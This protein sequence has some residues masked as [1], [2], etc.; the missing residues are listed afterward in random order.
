MKLFYRILFSLLLLFLIT[1]GFVA[2]ILISE[3][4]E[5]ASEARLN[6]VKTMSSA[7]A[8]GSLDALAVKDYELIE[9]WLSTSKAIDNFAYAYLS[10]SDGLIILHTEPEQVARQATPL[11]ELRSS[12]VRNLVYQHR[13]VIEVVSSTYLGSKHMANAHLAYYVDTTS[14]YSKKITNRLIVLLLLSLFVLSLVTYFIL[15]KALNPVTKLSIAIRDIAKSNNYSMFVKKYSDDEIGILVDSFNKMLKQ[16]QLRDDQLT[17]EK[18]HAENLATKTKIYAD[19]LELSNHELESEIS[20]RK[21]AENKLRKLSNTLEQKV[22]KRT[23]KLEEL[24][25]IVSEV[26]RNAGMAEV[27]NGILHNVGNVLNSVNVSSSVLRENISKSKL[28]NLSNVVHMIYDHKDELDA[29]LTYD[30]KGSQIPRFLKLLDEKLNTEHNALVLELNALDKNIDHITNIIRTQQSYAGHYGIVESIAIND[31]VEDALEIVFDKAQLDIID[32]DKYFA[33]VCK[34]QIDKHKAL[35]ILVNLLSNA[36]HALLESINS[37]KKLTIKLSENQGVISVVIADTGIGIAKEDVSH[38]FKY[39]FSNRPNGN[40][41]GLHN[42]ALLAHELG[43]EILVESEGL[44]EGAIF[45][46]L[47]KAN[48]EAA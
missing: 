37:T 31:L 17:T 2:N 13:P 46:F 10:K 42:C 34:V 26:S 6:Q 21:K 3:S 8:D 7:I 12:K 16:I 1:L 48:I 23:K 5:S 45:T 15:R 18:R 43:G 32:I 36:K 39:G 22:Q 4:R 24:N 9:R 35:Q 38:L 27:A 40:G 47:F 41:F 11:G 33:D 29:F 14:W 28:S 20:E 19:R 25:K 44:G 30:E